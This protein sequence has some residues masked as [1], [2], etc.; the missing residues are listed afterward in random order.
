MLPLL[1]APEVEVNTV[2]GKSKEKV[3][4][5]I[6]LEVLIDV[7]GWK[8]LGNRLSTHKVAKVELVA[9]QEDTGLEDGDDENEVIAVSETKNEKTDGSPAVKKKELESPLDPGEQ[10]SLFAEAPK[11]QAPSH[12]QK[13]EP[14]KKQAK[15]E[16]ASLFGEPQSQK[17]P[18][19]KENQQKE[20]QPQKES[21]PQKEKVKN[22]PDKDDKQYG[23]GDTIEFSI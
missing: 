13:N 10:A 5:T 7:K 11:N 22:D 21:Q 16:Q 4:E 23:V 17:Q 15:A 8:A 20:T 19:Q 1:E 9:D 18:P 2:R 6:N 12:Q 14:Q 3:K